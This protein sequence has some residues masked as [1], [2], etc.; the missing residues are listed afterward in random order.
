MAR[1]IVFYDESCRFCCRVVSLLSKLPRTEVFYEKAADMEQFTQHDD[2]LE[3]RYLD[4]YALFDDKVYKGY[5]SYL[6]IVNKTPL[7]KPLSLLMRI[8]YL[9]FMGEKIYRR[10]ADRRTCDHDVPK[11]VGN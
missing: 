7:L 2:A 8:F 10:I 1:L 9:R 6:Q 4:L 5:E 11:R 3:N